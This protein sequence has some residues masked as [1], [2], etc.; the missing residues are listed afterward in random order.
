MKSAPAPPMTLGA[1]TAAGLWLI[2]WCKGMPASGRAQLGRDGCSVRRRNDRARLARAA[3]RLGITPPAGRTSPVREGIIE[4]CTPRD[5]HPVSRHRRPAIEAPPA[6][7]MVWSPVSKARPPVP[8]LCAA[9]CRVA[10]NRPRVPARTATIPHPHDIRRRSCVA[11]PHVRP[12]PV[13]VRGIR[14]GYREW[15]G[16]RQ[17]ENTHFGSHYDAMGLCARAITVYRRPFI[18]RTRL[19]CVIFQASRMSRRQMHTA[20]A[21][22][23][24]PPAPR[25]AA[26]PESKAISS[27]P[28]QW[29][30]GLSRRFWSSELATARS[31]ALSSRSQDVARVLGVRAEDLLVRGRS[32]SQPL[33][34]A[35]TAPRPG[36]RPSNPIPNTGAAAGLGN[37]VPGSLAGARPG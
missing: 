1:A 23:V 24:H 2:V 12:R 35:S 5:K 30:G 22:S 25:I 27:P 21:V 7:L 13:G 34:T 4:D 31:V 8:S 33:V 29:P 17:A 18:P 37:G 6:V 16:E 32:G 11:W 28:D 10:R 3:C 26:G 20:Q 19:G 14:H 9:S 36:P 15:D